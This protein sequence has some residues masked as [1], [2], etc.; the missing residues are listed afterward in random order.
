MKLIVF[1]SVREKIKFFDLNSDL[2]LITLDILFRHQ[3]VN[4]F[5]Q[6]AVSCNYV[7]H[8]S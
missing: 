3:G 1:E 4:S 2:V 6:Q 7:F 5:V 8:Q